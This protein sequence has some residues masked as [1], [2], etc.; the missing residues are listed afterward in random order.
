MYMDVF[1]YWIETLKRRYNINALILSIE[2]GLAPENKY[3]SPMIECTEA[4]RYLLYT[5]KVFC[6]N[7]L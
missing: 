2:Y 4:Y 3:P 7:S 1:I 5:L 6:L